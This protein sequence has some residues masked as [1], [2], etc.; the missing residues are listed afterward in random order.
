M[1]L[2]QTYIHHNAA[3]YAHYYLCNY[4]PLS[5]GRD[6]FSY[7]LLKFKMGRQPDLSGWIDCSLEM[8][9]AGIP[10]SGLPDPGVPVSALIP[11]CSSIVRAL[12]HDEILVPEDPQT[13]LDLLGRA[14]AGRFQSLYLPSLIRK[15]RPARKISRL[16]IEQRE[17]EMK[18]IYIMNGFCMPPDP[19]ARLK[20]SFLIIDDILTTATTAKSILAAI[21]SHYPDASISLFTLA[22]ADYERHS[23]KSSPLRGQNYLLEQGMDWVV[24]EDLAEEGGNVYN[25]GQPEKEP[26][27]PYSGF[28]LK[29]WIC[30][31]TF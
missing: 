10:G 21:L 18:D 4:L 9:A 2:Q 29:A 11:A 23:N 5:A 1:A 8:L 19:P 27:S 20:P 14:L 24:A 17:A 7:S 12:H 30:S 28:Q 3:I 13:S 22:K 16:A 26:F 25:S 15:T 31:D 6:I